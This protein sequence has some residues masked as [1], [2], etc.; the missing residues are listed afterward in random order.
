MTE[1]LAMGGYAQFV[2]TAFG[3][4]LLTVIFNIV[5]ARRRE[6]SA[7]LQ[8]GQRIARDD[9]GRRPGHEIHHADP[10]PGDANS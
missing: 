9:S 2:W 1:F 6:K 4:T 5:T 10:A 7:L 3:L 8:I